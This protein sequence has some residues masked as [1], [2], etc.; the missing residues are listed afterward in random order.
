MNKHIGN[1]RVGLLNGGFHLMRDVMTFAHG[2]SAVY[3]Y[4]EIDIKV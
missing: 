4:V 2:N 1:A 3:F